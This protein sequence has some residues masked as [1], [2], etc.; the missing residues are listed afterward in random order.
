MVTVVRRVGFVPW[1]TLPCAQPQILRE[2][3]V[4]VSIR[5]VIE[6]VRCVDICLRSP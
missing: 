5:P 1:F 2:F 3:S 4:N 6:K